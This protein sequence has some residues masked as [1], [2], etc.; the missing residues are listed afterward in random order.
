M[1]ARA[2]VAEGLGTLLLL[3]VVVGSGIMGDSLSDGSMGLALLANSIATGLALAV[4]IFALGPLSG[5][6]FNP[7]V[8][9]AFC[10]RGDT[11]WRV[12]PA[13]VAVQVI[14]GVLGVVLTHAMFGMDLLQTAA[15]D[16]GAPHLWVSEVVA[17]FGLILV[18]FAGVRYHVASVPWLVGAYIA[19]A[20]WFTA[21]T[22]F[23]NP[24][25]T[26]ARALTETFAGIAPAHVG[27]FVGMQLLGA[28]LAWALCHWLYAPEPPQPA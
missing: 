12:A 27:A 21:S 9:L 1:N 10:L 20:Y 8:T 4:L 3:A 16:R 24:A 14:G 19:S 17:T 18:I 22:S 25:V 7:A 5:A 13:Y 15:T 2:L 23:A 6:H 28:V 26:L 11:P